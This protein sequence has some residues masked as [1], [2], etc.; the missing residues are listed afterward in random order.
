MC[1]LVSRQ[2]QKLA[3]EKAKVEQL[4]RSPPRTPSQQDLS[5]LQTNLNIFK[6]EL[7]KQVLRSNA[8]EKQA[9]RSGAL[10]K[11][12]TTE[13]AARERAQQQLEQ[14][15][16]REHTI[17]DV[18]YEAACACDL[19]LSNYL[20]RTVHSS[21]TRNHVSCTY[22]SRTCTQILYIVQYNYTVQCTRVYDMIR[23]RTQTNTFV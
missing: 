8:F 10:E 18:V 14:A 20:Y 4:Q 7:S 9:Q 5:S 3:A 11:E 6:E 21:L 17:Y 15:Q 1:V 2:E 19:L 13:R 16:V 12:L 22:L 23:L